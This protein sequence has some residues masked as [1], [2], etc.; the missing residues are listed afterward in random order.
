MSL[1]FV[2]KV[3]IDNNPALNKREAIIWTNADPIDWRIYTAREG[4]E[5][6]KV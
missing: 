5:L 1:K 3:P 4:D 2:P 6:M